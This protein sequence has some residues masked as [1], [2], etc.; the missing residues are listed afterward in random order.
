MVR[1]ARFGWHDAGPLDGQLQS[2]DWLSDD[3]EPALEPR[4]V[5]RRGR[6]KRTSPIDRTPPGNTPP[7]TGDRAA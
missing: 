7:E 5:R 4:R 1:L 3:E 2:P 6:L